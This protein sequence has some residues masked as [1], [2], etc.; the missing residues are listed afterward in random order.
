MKRSRNIQR[1]CSSDSILLGQLDCLTNV[2]HGS[3]EDNLTGRIHIGDIHIGFLSDSPD[4]RFVTADESSHG[5]GR[6]VTSLLHVSSA[7]RTQAEAVQEI[8]GAGRRMRRKS[9]EREAGRRYDLKIS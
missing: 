8:E 1:N 7:I 9:P 2:F 4:I 6:S 3:R 5:P